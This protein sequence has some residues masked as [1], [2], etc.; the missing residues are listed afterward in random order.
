MTGE[1]RHAAAGPRLLLHFLNRLFQFEE[2]R[3]AAGWRVIN[4]AAIGGDQRHAGVLRV[5]FGI[6]ERVCGSITK[7]TVEQGVI[8]QLGGS[9]LLLQLR[10]SLSALSRTDLLLAGRGAEGPAVIR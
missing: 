3:V 9:P 7:V 6:C 10:Q 2:R 4:R 1:L 5:G 8:Q